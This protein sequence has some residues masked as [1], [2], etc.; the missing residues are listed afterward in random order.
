MNPDEMRVDLESFVN[1]GMAEGWS[2]WPLKDRLSGHH[3]GIRSIYYR[4]AAGATGSSHNVLR[5]VFPEEGR[6]G[7]ISGSRF[8][9]FLE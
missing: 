7:Q 4:A 1:K 8:S 9:D 5:R 2:G 3:E 6:F